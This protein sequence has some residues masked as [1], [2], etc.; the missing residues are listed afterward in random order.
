M[1]LSPDALVERQ[2]VLGTL[3]DCVA[4][5]AAGAGRA[6]VV[7][8]PPGIGKSALLAAFGQVA[9][10]SGCRMLTAR[11]GEL[12]SDFAFG[13]VRQLLESPVRSLEAAERD[14]V[15]SGSAGL[16]AGL[17]GLGEQAEAGN[18]MFALM[19]GLYWACANL[20]EQRPLVIV[21]DDAHWADAP[22]LR[23]LH[24]LGRRLDG[25]PALVVLAAR[26][27]GDGDHAGLLDAIRADENCDELQLAP[28]TE[29]GTAGLLRLLLGTDP[30]A[31]LARVCHRVSAG[32]PFL[33]VETARS[34]TDAGI[35]EA[36]PAVRRIL[37]TPA[38]SI[39]RS[40]LTRLARLP[41]PVQDIA[42]AVT[43]LGD[44]TTLHQ[45][46]SFAGQSVAE[47]GTALDT[48][49]GAALLEPA[50]PLRFSHALIRAALYAEIPAGVRA[51]EHARAARVLAA[52]GADPEHAAA[53]LLQVEGQA[54]PWSVEIL[55]DAAREAV[56]NGAADVAATYLRR[57]LAEPPPQAAKG[58]LLRMLGRVLTSQGDR[59]GVDAFAAALDL[60]EQPRE[61][62]LVGGEL[63]VALMW[64]ARFDEAVDVLGDAIGDE[65]GADPD[66]T[67]RLTAQLSTVGRLSPT[68]YERTAKRLRRLAPRLA[69]DDPSAAPG[70]AS[71][72][73]ERGMRGGDADQLAA[74]VEPAAERGWY[75]AFS[76]PQSFYDAMYVL[77][78]TDRFVL[79]R[80]MLDDIDAKVRQLGLIAHLGHL[81]AFRADL[82]LRTGHLAEAETAARE[83][84][85]SDLALDSPGV[86]MTAAH[87]CQTLL[88]RGETDAAYDVLRVVA[89]LDHIPDG[90][91][92]NFLLFARGRLRVE[93]GQYAEGL[94]DLLELAKREEPTRR[95]VPAML[96]WR[97]TAAMAYLRLGQAD[98]A[99][100]LTSREVEL[101]RRFGARR[102]LGVA[103]RAS[104]LVRGDDGLKELS[105]AVAVLD[106][107]GARLEHARAL[108]DLGAALRRT[109]RRGD[110]RDPLQRAIELARACSARALAER[111]Q[112]ELRATGAR[113]RRLVF[114]GVESLTASERRVAKL[115]AQGRSNREIAEHLF[116]TRKTV[117]THLGA[118]YRKLSIN[119][120]DV[121]AELL[122]VEDRTA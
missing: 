108:T 83:R 9:R 34:L 60:T 105:E 59:D 97:S 40:A 57:A 75:D 93:T 91:M 100:R 112:D 79:A 20:A 64:A 90:W 62:S 53:H 69:M 89:A 31:E 116:V 72:A 101:T 84:F 78:I 15:L 25:V 4:G 12:E 86:P 85:E 22:S 14:F 67:L 3:A 39:G 28:L 11:G 46:A 109:N 10:E 71:L 80:R 77:T 61:R 110:A 119:G 114:T 23:W 13:V 29:S 92:P 120:R 18:D 65:V 68:S 54:D 104:G 7:E 73:I 30:D 102:A 16:C 45:A 121:L 113:P 88:D 106:G 118:V 56:Q 8:G 103:L 1:D 35:T 52:L 94:A 50:T 81:Q 111:A 36:G 82:D 74:M 33:L 42:R 2:A 6:V 63:S 19:H 122:D 58:E 37:D 117:E 76:A 44:G 48:L 98:E 38:E 95:E 99:A 26:T 43:I 51:R 32:N 70:L 66:L 41:G 21:V 17:L 115:A 24:Y 55:S 27:T 107:S 96:P 5:T 49:A 47:A 87:L